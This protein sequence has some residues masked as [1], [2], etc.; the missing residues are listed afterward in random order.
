MLYLLKVPV[1]SGDPRRQLDVDGPELEEVL[2]PRH[3]AVATVQT[4]LVVGVA[5]SLVLSCL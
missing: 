2:G 4:L 5:W 1:R 3:L